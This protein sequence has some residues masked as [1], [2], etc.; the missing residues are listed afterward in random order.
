MA[1]R[2]NWQAEVIYDYFAK[3]SPQDIVEY[4]EEAVQYF[5][6]VAP[7]TIGLTKKEE[8]R[9]MGEELKKF[10][11]QPSKFKRKN[12]PWYPSAIVQRCDEGR[13][14]A[15]PVAAFFPIMSQKGF[16]KKYKD[17]KGK[18]VGDI[19][20]KKIKSN[21]KGIWQMQFQWWPL[22]D[23]PMDMGFFMIRIPN[24][25]YEIQAFYPTKQYTEKQLNDLLK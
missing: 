20:C 12:N 15:H 7:K 2:L 3:Y 16:I 25:P 17:V 22:T 6:K 19:L 13:V 4:A 24:T 1:Y 14:V 18:K 5:S 23:K 11:Q 10:Y 9:I 21:T 8:E